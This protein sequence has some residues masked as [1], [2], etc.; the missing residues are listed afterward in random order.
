[1]LFQRRRRRRRVLAAGQV[2]CV[3]P[4]RSISFL[5]RSLCCNGQFPR[6]RFCRLCS[7]PSLPW[8][9]WFQS[10]ISFDIRVVADVVVA[11]VVVADVVVAAAA[12]GSLF[13]RL[14]LRFLLRGRPT[15]S[16]IARCCLMEND[17][18]RKASGLSVCVSVCVC[19]FCW[20]VAEEEEEEEEEEWWGDGDI[21]AL[22]M[23]LNGLIGDWSG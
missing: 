23:N 15:A 5:L 13:E 21:N 16:I 19:P 2:P 1:M 12:V 6:T 14:L 22:R 3:S 9:S 8:R 17:R 20:L 7:N 10:F 18:R 11:D 4:G